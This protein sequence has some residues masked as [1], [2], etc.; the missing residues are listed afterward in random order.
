MG[1]QLQL[2]SWKWKKKKKNRSGR[3]EVD[4]G[5][6]GGQGLGSML[7]EE[8]AQENISSDAFEVTGRASRGNMVLEVEPW[9]GSQKTWFLTQAIPPAH[10]SI[11]RKSLHP[12]EPQGPHL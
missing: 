11:L 9:A 10:V 1:N 5:Q 4:F 7:C 2:L 6:E 8:Q 3:N 12:P